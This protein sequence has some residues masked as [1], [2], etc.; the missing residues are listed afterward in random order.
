MSISL[1]KG[2]KISLSK[3][4]G[5]LGKVI[6]GLGWDEAPRNTRKGLFGLFGS[7]P[8]SIDCDA[9]AILLQNGKLRDRDDIVF[10]GNLKHSTNM[11]NHMGDNLT[12]AGEG[13][14]EQI[15]IDLNH[16]PER[17]DRIVI[18]V[19]IYSA[20]IKKQHFGMIQNAFVRIVD[21][22]NNSEL[23]KYNLTEN[24]SGCLAM[25][26]GEI[27]RHNGEWKFNAIGQGTQDGNIMDLASR[28]R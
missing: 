19:N 2:Q 17:Y 3:E 1:Q 24:Y 9:S 5:G 16:L 8:E 4:H 15:V 28:Y 13:D 20:E 11:V 25:I 27:Y 14:D 18:V 21:M 23:C 26:F 22:K 12:G 7:K 6:V 10:F